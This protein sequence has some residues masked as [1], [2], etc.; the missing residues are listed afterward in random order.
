MAFYLWKNVNSGRKKIWHSGGKKIKAS[1]MAATYSSTQ[2][3]VQ[4]HRREQ[5]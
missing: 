5:A 1:A 2:S 4:Y 3:P